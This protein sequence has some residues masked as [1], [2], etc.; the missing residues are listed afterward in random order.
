M[1]LLSSNL[2]TL[3]FLGIEVKHLH[4][5]SLLLTQGKYIRDLLQRTDMLGAKSISTPFPGNMKLSKHGS[6]Y[7]DDPVT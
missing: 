3:N 6:D 4:N 1:F 5:G 7:F 2:E